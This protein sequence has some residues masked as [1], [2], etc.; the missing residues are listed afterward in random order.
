MAWEK[1]GYEEILKKIEKY[2]KK[3]VVDG[4]ADEFHILSQLISEIIDVCVGVL[5]IDPPKECNNYTN[6]YT[7]EEYK[8]LF[9]DL[10]WVTTIAFGE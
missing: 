10:G 3:P 1:K 2:N 4:Y 5:G 8:Q 6:C 7:V 9:S